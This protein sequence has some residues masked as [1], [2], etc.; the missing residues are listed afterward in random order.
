MVT[1]AE[2]QGLV[3]VDLVAGRITLR[4]EAA[5]SEG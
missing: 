1:D 4:G 5:G 2:K 3:K